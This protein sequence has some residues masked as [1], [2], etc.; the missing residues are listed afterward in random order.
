[1][2]NVL[3]ISYD[4]P[5][6]WTSGVY[7]PLK[8]AKYLPKFGW[9]P[10]I[11]TV[12]NYPRECLDETLLEQLPPETCI[13]RARSWEPIRLEKAIFSRLYLRKERKSDSPDV[14]DAGRPQLKTGRLSLLRRFFFAPLSWFTANCVYIPDDKIGW[15][16]HAVYKGLRAIRQERIDVIMSTSPPETAHIVALLLKLITG[17]PWIADFRDPWT[18]NPYRIGLPRIRCGLENRIER[19]VIRRADMIIHVGEEMAALSSSRFPDIPPEK[20]HVITNGFDEED[21]EGLAA[22]DIRKPDKTLQLK[23]TNIG[24]LYE[25]SGFENFLKGLERVITNGG[26]RGKIRVTFVGQLIPAWRQA[27]ARQTFRDHVDLLGFKPHEETLRYM[28]AADVLLLM[29][30]ETDDRTAGTIVTGKVFELMRAGRPILMIGCEGECSRIIEKSGLGRFIPS[31]DVDLISKT[32]MEYYRK[33]LDGKLETR[34]DRD[35]IYQ[36]ERKKLTGE[37]ARLLEQVRRK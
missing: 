9:R 37:L 19:K 31:H 12:K 34:P 14:G 2:K 18:D 11:L 24:T 15:V 26:L 28:M 21:F 27:L 4:F 5:P 7:R 20:H 17:K 23:L 10:V 16:P 29:P 22:T 13:T 30:L 35:F 32:I 6:A 3:L 33:K 8:F 25:L 1:M 36:F